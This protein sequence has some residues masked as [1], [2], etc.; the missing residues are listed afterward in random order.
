MRYNVS[1]FFILSRSAGIALG[2]WLA[3]ALPVTAAEPLVLL[4]QPILSEEQTRKAFK[5]LC[6]FI[7]QHT[8]R[9]CRIQTAPNFLAYWDTVRRNHGYDLALDAAHFTDYRMQKHG[10]QVLAKMPDS[11][12]YSL[13]VPGDALVIEP[14]ELIGKTIAT[15]GPPSIGAARLNAL[16]PNPSR[17]PR[18]LDV[19]SVE[20]GVE[21]VAKKRVQGAILPTPVV[22]QQQARG[23]SIQVVMTTEPIP[24]IALSA[25][26]TLDSALRERLRAA[27][28]DADRSDDGRRM[29]KNIGFARLDPAGPDLYANQ[30]RLL[31][32][33]WGY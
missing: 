21:L 4:I 8:Q 1:N 23:V 11:V 26:P 27:L 30:S 31:R 33:Y 24:H 6:E 17:Q 5:P 10:F 32:E 15:L 28:L 16:Y 25:S 22:A 13:I 18:I 3:L 2:L 19:N 14:D 12:S 9:D 7:A 29:L 20:E